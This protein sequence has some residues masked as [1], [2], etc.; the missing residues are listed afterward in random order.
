MNNLGYYIIAYGWFASD[1]TVAL[2]DG[3]N[4]NLSLRWELNFIIMPIQQQEIVLYCHPTWLPCHVGQT[5][6]MN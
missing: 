6:N 5:K 2:L 1:V 3:M 4:N